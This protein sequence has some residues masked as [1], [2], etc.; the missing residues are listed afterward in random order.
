MLPHMAS[1]GLLISRLVPLLLVASAFLI[2]ARVSRDS[3]ERHGHAVGGRM[4][5]LGIITA[6]ALIS[7]YVLVRVGCLTYASLAY[8]DEKWPNVDRGYRSY[9]ALGGRPSAPM[10]H[11]WGVALM[12]G[13]RWREAASLF[14]RTGRPTPRGP[15][16]DPD[17]VLLI[18]ECLYHGGDFARAEQALTAARRA[19]NAF[20]REYYLGMLADRRGDAIASTGHFAAALANNPR[21]FPALYQLAR[22]SVAHGDRDGV[23]AAMQRFA[24]LDPGA[25]RSDAWRMLAASLAP[26]APPPPRLEFYVLES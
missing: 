15:A 11:E 25:T 23:R 9:A 12:H 17:A 5:F 8:V 14:V 24:P 20:A 10:L 4:T 18:G 3:L 26:N 13:Q 19:H 22:L 7:A 16:L 2:V 6:A 21:F 1:Y